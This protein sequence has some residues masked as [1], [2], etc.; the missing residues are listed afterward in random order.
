MYWTKAAHSPGNNMYV[1]LTSSL[2]NIVLHFSLYWEPPIIVLCC[3]L[4]FLRWVQPSKGRCCCWLTS[5]HVATTHADYLA[6]CSDFVWNICCSCVWDAWSWTLHYTSDQLQNEPC[7]AQSFYHLW[8]RS[9]QSAQHLTPWSFNSWNSCPLHSYQEREKC[10]PWEAKNSVFH[11]QCQNIIHC[12]YSRTFC[13]LPKDASIM[14]SQS[15]S[16]FF[17][18]PLASL[19]LLKM[20]VIH[21]H[22]TKSQP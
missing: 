1:F 3:V 4:Q 12:H 19:L 22:I 11:R 14:F 18:H 8:T 10:I 16:S 9:V 21:L 7:T 2:H 5:H 17:K 6:L 15:F 13:H 20:N